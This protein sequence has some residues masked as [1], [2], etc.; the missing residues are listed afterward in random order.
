[1]LP[2][3]GAAKRDA[4]V[5]GEAILIFSRSDTARHGGAVNSLQENQS[6]GRTDRI[7]PAKR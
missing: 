4:F 1:M 5:D 7:K 2:E 3:F 6:V